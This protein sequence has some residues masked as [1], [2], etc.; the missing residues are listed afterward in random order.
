MFGEDEGKYESDSDNFVEWPVAAPFPAFVRIDDMGEGVS[1]S[2]SAWAGP[3][4]ARAAAETLEAWI[5]WNTLSHPDPVHRAWCAAQPA[6]R[7]QRL[8]QRARMIAGVVPAP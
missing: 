7:M 2:W 6:A 8:R 1:W 5:A 4:G 3:A